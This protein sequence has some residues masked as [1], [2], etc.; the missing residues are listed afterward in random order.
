MN[1][2]TWTLG[3]RASLADYGLSDLLEDELLF[4]KSLLLVVQPL[5]GICRLYISTGPRTNV[6]NPVSFYLLQGCFRPGTPYLGTWN[7]WLYELT[8]VKSVLLDRVWK[9]R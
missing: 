8:V 1:I 3:V 7:A 4:Q 5:L 2:Q 9:M 6:T